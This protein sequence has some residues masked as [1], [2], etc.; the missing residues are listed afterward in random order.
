LRL[1]IGTAQFGQPYGIANQSGQLTRSEVKA[2][3]SLARSVGIDTLDTASA[4]GESEVCLGKA[5][6]SDF[7]VVTKLP[8]DLDS[9][10]SARAWV[11]DRMQTSLRRLRLST[12]YA[13]LI[14]RS[15]QLSGVRGKEIAR[16]LNNLKSEGIV[17]KVGV[18]IYSPAEL[19]VVTKHFAVD[20]VQAPLSLIDRRL[21]SSGWLNRLHDA[22]VEIH[23]R[24]VFLQGLMLISGSGVPEQFAPWNNLWNEWHDWLAAREKISAAQACIG[25]VQSFPE[26]DKIVVGVDSASQL[27]QLVTAAAHQTTADW[28]AIDTEDERLINPSNWN[29][30]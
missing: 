17:E 6:T 15:D 1:A 18:S 3:L 26:V 14:H 2:V 30:L 27:E 16:E 11:R 25:F 21:Y 5:G 24:S 28:P 7:K 23:V 13:A 9:S 10:S 8:A 12:I 19:D 20:L 4:Y 22:G 29:A